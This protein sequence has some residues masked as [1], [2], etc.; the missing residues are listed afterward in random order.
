MVQVVEGLM[1]R[2]PDLRWMRL[3][4]LMVADP[5]EPMMTAMEC[6]SEHA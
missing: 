3:N 2:S 5:V 6:P 4:P 1:L